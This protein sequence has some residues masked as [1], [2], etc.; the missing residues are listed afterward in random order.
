MK[1]PF[2][3]R[4]ATIRLLLL[5]YHQ[6]IPKISYY[7]IIRDI[8]YIPNMVGKSPLHPISYLFS[9]GLRTSLREQHGSCCGTFTESWTPRWQRRMTNDSDRSGGGQGGQ[10]PRIFVMKFYV[11]L[12]FYPIIYIY[13]HII[14]IYISWLCHVVLPVATAVLL[15]GCS[16]GHLKPSSCRWL[17]KAPAP[18]C[19]HQFPS[20]IKDPVPFWVYHPSKEPVS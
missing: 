5:K 8:N 11:V 6:H 3:K 1:T 14:Y 12:P 16:S 7:I 20:M 4:R 15:H 17:V 10:P 9:M 18:F 19:E 2:R 13:I